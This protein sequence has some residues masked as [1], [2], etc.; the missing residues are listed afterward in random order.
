MCILHFLTVTLRLHKV[1][2]KKKYLNDKILDPIRVDFLARVLAKALKMLFSIFP[3]V[4]IKF[5]TFCLNFLAVR[6]AN[7][8]ELTRSAA[9]PLIV[10]EF[11]FLSSGPDKEIHR[12]K[13]PQQVALRN[14][15]VVGKCL[16]T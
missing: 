15:G 7:E 10:S 16:D 8:T 4:L 14:K 6:V 13:P 5:S 3:P 1:C 9:L 2:W 12:P 11:H